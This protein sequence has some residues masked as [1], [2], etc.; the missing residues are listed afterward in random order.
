M[1]I[2][3]LTWGGIFSFLAVLDK[4]LKDLQREIKEN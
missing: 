2:V 3:L 1:V 4:R